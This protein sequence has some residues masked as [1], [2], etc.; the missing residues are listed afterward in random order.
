MGRAILL[1]AISIFAFKS[2]LKCTTEAGIG[3]VEN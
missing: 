2:Q 1:S 3:P